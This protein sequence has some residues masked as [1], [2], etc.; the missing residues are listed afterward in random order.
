MQFFSVTILSLVSTL[1][2][3]ARQS[4]RTLFGPTPPIGGVGPN[5]VRSNYEAGTSQIGINAVLHDLRAYLNR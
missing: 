4:G 2:I 3:P 5:K 1:S